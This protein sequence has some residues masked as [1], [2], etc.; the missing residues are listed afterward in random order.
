MALIWEWN[1]IYYLHEDVISEDVPEEQ[2][3]DGGDVHGEGGALGK[4]G[5]G[6][7]VDHPIRDGGTRHVTCEEIE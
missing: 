5:S 3:E 2:L 1:T 4:E 6:G 7:R